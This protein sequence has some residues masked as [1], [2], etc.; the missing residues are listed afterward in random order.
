MIEMAKVP[1]LVGVVLVVAACF[2][3]GLPDDGDG[4]AA[5]AVADGTPQAGAA[6]PGPA[7]VPG[8]W[9]TIP[10]GTFMMGSPDGEPCRGPEPYHRVTLT[11]RFEIQSTEVTQSQF[12]GVMGYLAGLESSASCPVDALSWHELAAYCNALSAKAGLASCYDCTGSGAAVSCSNAAAY[13]GDRV[14]SCP[15]YRLP[16]HAEWEYAYRAGTTT[17]YYNGANDPDACERCDT[18]DTRADAIAWYCANTSGPRPAGEK[19]PNP[20]GLFDMAGNVWEWCHDRC[21]YHPGSAAVIDPVHENPGWNPDRRN[22]RGGSWVYKAEH[23]RAA[24]CGSFYGTDHYYFDIGG[25]CVRT[26]P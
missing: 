12:Q 18:I 6:K 7:G 16:T 21:G 1:A 20:W 13:G 17:P 2:R 8:L 3:S 23:A 15:G 25:R 14:Y 11:R 10:A 5:T 19:Q 4:S 26:L 9:V 22:A 24:S